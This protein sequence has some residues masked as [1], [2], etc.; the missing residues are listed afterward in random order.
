MNPLLWRLRFAA[1]RP[2]REEVREFILRQMPRRGVVAEIG[3][4]LGD[5]S[6]KILA[7][8]RPRV[9]HL[10]DPWTAESGEYRQRL[11]DSDAASVDSPRKLDTVARFALVR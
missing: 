10:I 5:F 2:E 8:N 11:P 9:L 7:L 1:R 4:D 3:V 6:E